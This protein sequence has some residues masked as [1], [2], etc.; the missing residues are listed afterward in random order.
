MAYLNIINY[1]DVVIT[2]DS[3]LLAFQAPN[4]LYKLGNNLYGNLINLK[5]LH[6][7][8]DLNFKN[9]SFDQFTLFCILS[10]CDYCPSPYGISIKTS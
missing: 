7:N 6:N 9:W 1:V 8:N 10:G 4:I 2:E 3:D 5:E